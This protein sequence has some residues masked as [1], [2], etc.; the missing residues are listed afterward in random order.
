MEFSLSFTRQLLGD[1]ASAMRHLHSRGIMHGDLYAH[2]VFANSQGQGLLGDLEAASLY[3]AGS[4]DGAARERVD[5]RGFGYLIDDLLSH[6]AAGT[7]E[8]DSTL[9]ELQ[10]LRGVC[11][12]KAAN[13]RPSFAD[14]HD[15]LR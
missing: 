10:N 9:A 1:I 8:D 6:Q 5:V 11:L 4:A 13:D 15:S 3:G 14:I 12:Q 2:N 7:A